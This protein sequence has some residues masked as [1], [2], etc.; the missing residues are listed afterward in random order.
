[1]SGVKNS[2]VLFR[3][4]LPTFVFEAISCSKK[5]VYKAEHNGKIEIGHENDV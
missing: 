3:L 4:I 5:N 2:Y 1:M